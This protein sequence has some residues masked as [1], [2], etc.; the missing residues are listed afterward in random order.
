MEALMQN[1]DILLRYMD[2]KETYVKGKIAYIDVERLLMAKITP[3]KLWKT[4]NC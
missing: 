2:I 1:T 4:F 3:W